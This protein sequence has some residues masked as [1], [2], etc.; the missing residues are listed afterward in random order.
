MRYCA[1][2][3]G[4]RQTVVAGVDIGL[5]FCMGFKRTKKL[6]FKVRGNKFLLMVM[7]F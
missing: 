2:L 1:A 5:K 4:Y 6:R 7:G 3:D